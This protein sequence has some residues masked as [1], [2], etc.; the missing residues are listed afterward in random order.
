[1]HHI[2]LA[3]DISEEAE[4]QARGK[5]ITGITL[6]VGELA[7]ATPT[8]IKEGLAHLNDWDVTIIPVKAVVKCRCGHKGMPR[9]LERSHDFVFFECPVCGETPNVL[10][11]DDIRLVSVEVNDE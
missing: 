11:G 7:N 10:E 6:H 3:N 9:V 1:M 8:Q 5:N 2:T 4:K